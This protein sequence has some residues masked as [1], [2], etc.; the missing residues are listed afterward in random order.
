MGKRYAPEEAPG[1]APLF[2]PPH[3]GTPTSKAAAKS[4]ESRAATM[5]GRILAFV[6]SR[7]EIGALR[8]DIEIA[9][10]MNGST[11]RPRVLELI[12]FGTLKEL[13]ATRATSS[14][15]QATVLVAT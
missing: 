12:R 13:E 15:R 5:R 10:D 7:G 3:N 4:I 1:Y 9:L 8:E 6:R 14:G 2:D 11:V